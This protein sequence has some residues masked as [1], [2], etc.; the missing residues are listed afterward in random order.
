MR[1]GEGV[2]D[3][4]Q[5]LSISLATSDNLMSTIRAGVPSAPAS[6]AHD[7]AQPPWELNTLSDPAGSYPS[8]VSPNDST[9]CE[10]FPLSSNENSRHP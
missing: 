6:P 2:A 10:G 3:A 1:L 7:V 8:S 4:V 9:A 5:A